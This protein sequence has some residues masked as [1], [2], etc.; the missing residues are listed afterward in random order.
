TLTGPNGIGSAADLKLPLR[1]ANAVIAQRILRSIPPNGSLE[2][3]S[4]LLT[5]IVP[6]TGA[7][8]LSVAS[9]PALDD[10]SSLEALARYPLPCTEQSVSRALPLDYLSQPGAGPGAQDE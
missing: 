9:Y 8:N 2:F 7:V 6:G 10:A 1:P 5:D 4:E 3:G